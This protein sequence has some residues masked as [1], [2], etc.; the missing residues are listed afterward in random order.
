MSNPRI[1]ELADDEIPQQNVTAQ[2]AGDSDSD[3]DAGET[4]DNVT[5]GST[6]VVHSRNEKKAR[7]SIA[8]LGLIRV[9]GITRV[10]MKRAKGVSCAA[11]LLCCGKCDW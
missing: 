8:K 6:T 2:D 11:F 7:K 10:T 9:Q 3:S 1:E 4:G 5:S